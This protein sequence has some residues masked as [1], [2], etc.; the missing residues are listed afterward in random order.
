L[1]TSLLLWCGELK[2][3]LK[4]IYAGNLVILDPSFSMEQL[5]D[6]KQQYAKATQTYRNTGVI[7][8]ISHPHSKK[9]AR[10]SFYDKYRE[11]ERF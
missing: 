1:A 11:R 8:T 6:K 3:N 2:I 7:E 5:Q 9:V 4:E 10:H